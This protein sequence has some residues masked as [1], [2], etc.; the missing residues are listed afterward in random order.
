GGR[1]GEH[2]RIALARRAPLHLYPLADLERIEVA[3]NE[4]REQRD[5]LVER[6]V[7]DRV[8]NRRVPA[9]DAEGVDLA[10]AL[11][12]LPAGVA[13]VAERADRA[14]IPVRLAAGA[15]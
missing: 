8:G 11:A 9:H 2:R 7:A 6:H 4:V 12:L 13:G 1:E 15:A 5:A 3:V 10:L 14:R